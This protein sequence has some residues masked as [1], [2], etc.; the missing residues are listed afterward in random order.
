[1][2]ISATKKSGLVAQ[3]LHISHVPIQPKS[4]HANKPRA[5]VAS[6]IYKRSRE[7]LKNLVV[8]RI[9]QKGIMHAS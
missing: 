1:M 6:N 5:V 7:V 3:T 2:L 8:F 4:F 9:W